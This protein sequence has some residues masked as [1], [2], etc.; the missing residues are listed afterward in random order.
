MKEPIHWIISVFLAG[1]TSC[2]ALSDGDEMNDEPVPIVLSPWVE[3][4]T[5]PNHLM[6]TEAMTIPYPGTEFKINI[7]PKAPEG[8]ADKYKRYT[9]QL[10]ATK[11]GDKWDLTGTSGLP[12]AAIGSGTVGL[13][14]AA[15]LWAGRTVETTINAWAGWISDFPAASPLDNTFLDQKTK[16]DLTK[17][18]LL[19]YRD[20][21]IPQDKLGVEMEG[22]FTFAFHHHLSQ[23]NVKLVFGLEYD[24]ISSS[25]IL[26]GGI[27]VAGIFNTINSYKFD[28]DKTMADAVEPG[29]LSTTGVNTFPNKTDGADLL[30]DVE[31]ITP[32][33]ESPVKEESGHYVVSFKALLVPQELK[34]N[35]ELIIIRMK[36][37]NGTGD[38]FKKDGDV[39]FIYPLLNAEKLESG[40]AYTLTLQMGG[41]VVSTVRNAI[42]ATLQKGDWQ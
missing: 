41:T 1:L 3:N 27:R 17:A 15:P 20:T 31:Y 19:H 11:T 25:D 42:N 33:M 14:G 21:F 5:E 34:A 9:Y 13:N 30:K 36:P 24:Q 40:K 6:K 4:R 18:D 22:K 29:K 8:N 7:T 2:A 28:P 16:D 26:E 10:T 37:L 23:L 35:T 12:D 39:W 38:G 32:C